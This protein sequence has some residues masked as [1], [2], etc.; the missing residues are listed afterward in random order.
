[1]MMRTPLVW[2]SVATLLLLL[3]AAA[4]A[5]DK[6]P[7]GPPAPSPAAK[8][9]SG[10]PAPS[11]TAKKPVVTEYHGVKVVDDYR[12][13]ENWAD[14]A[15]RR[16]SDE[17]NRYARSVLDALPGAA[18]L[19]KRVG[20]LM[21]FPST[22]FGSLVRRRGTLFAMKTEPPKQQP[23]LVVLTSPDDPGSAR[24]IVDPNVLDPKGATA[25][26]FFVPSLDGKLVAV[27]LSRGG[28]ESGDVHVYEVATGKPLP[29]VIP[30]VNGGTAGGS[31]AW[32]SD[33]SGFY[34]T[35]Y[36][37]G[38]ERPR[39]DLDFF[40]QVWFHRLGTPLGFDAYSLGQ[41]FP[42][43]AEIALHTSDDGLFVLASVEN[44]D[45]GD[46]AHYL[47]TPSRGWTRI[48]DFA[49]RV[50]GAEFGPD[51]SLYLVSRNGAPRGKVL[52]LAPGAS[53]L[54][55]AATVFPEGPAVSRGSRPRRR[56]ST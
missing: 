48:A 8:K 16:F 12:W 28:S 4:I 7:S 41:D 18:A 33:G 11:L 2:T 10:P 9:T 34:Y 29:D 32:N 36:P 27:S 20:D 37:R 38:K 17:E 1:M 39:E 42:R 24:A 43:I 45:G 46:Y 54:A 6:Q 50:V 21:R 22:G 3:N 49:D 15:V 30:R 31:L 14:P 13:L 26:D 35:R 53:N 44:G 52:R 47:L 25:I 51:G 19:R 5:G 55:A 23:F 56:S 40:Q